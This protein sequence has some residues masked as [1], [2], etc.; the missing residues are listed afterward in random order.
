M[1][2]RLSGF[3]IKD[4]RSD[5]VAGLTFALVNVPQCLGEALLATVNPVFGIYTLMIA[6][7]VA[8]LVTSSVFMNVSTTGALS[9]A[10]GAGLTN[11]PPDQRA[12]ALSAFGDIL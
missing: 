8:A 11:V 12:E 7:P 4:L 6:A 9:V 1:N 10:T 2:S 3:S 5:L